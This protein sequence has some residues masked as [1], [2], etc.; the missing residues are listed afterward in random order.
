M[1]AL[2]ILGGHKVRPYE[3]LKQS[4]PTRPVVL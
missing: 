3:L 1:V 2:M 4:L